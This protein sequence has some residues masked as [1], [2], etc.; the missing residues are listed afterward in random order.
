MGAGP[1]SS[2]STSTR[3]DRG[4]VSMD[5]CPGSGASTARSRALAPRVICAVAVHGAWPGASTRTCQLTGRADL[6]VSGVRPAS[7][8]WTST[9]APDGS[10]ST[11]ALA[12]SSQMASAMGPTA[13]RASPAIGSQLGGDNRGGAALSAMP[14]ACSSG[15]SANEPCSRS[16]RVDQILFPGAAFGSGRLARLR[17][18]AVL[19][20]VPSHEV[21]VTPF[22]TLRRKGEGG[23]APVPS[24]LAGRRL[25]TGE[26]VRNP[27]E[28][29]TQLPF[30]RVWGAPRSCFLASYQTKLRSVYTRGGIWLFKPRFASSASNVSRMMGGSSAWG[31]VLPS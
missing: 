27:S 22:P 2:P 3:A 4:S 29:Y 24:P 28:G 14:P 19:P 13:P 12:S 6:R 25:G 16:Q 21:G 10:D 7:L 18:V 8:P 9:T 11:T 5:S 26:L 1:R 31:S 20:A 30:D 23:I 15:F 17:R